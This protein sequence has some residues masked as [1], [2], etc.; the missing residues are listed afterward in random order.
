MHGVKEHMIE[1]RDRL[2]ELV[3]ELKSRRF[4]GFIKINFSQG[5]ITRIEQ[6]EEILKKAK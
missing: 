6:N 5:G 1:K 3:D 4:T 2:I